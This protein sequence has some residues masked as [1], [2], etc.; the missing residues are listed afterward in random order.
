MGE[1][2]T[3][4]SV[5]H[6]LE[7]RLEEIMTNQIKPIPQATRQFSIQLTY[8]M[9]D[10]LDEIAKQKKTKRSKLIF[11]I[12]SEYLKKVKIESPITVITLIAYIGYFAAYYLSL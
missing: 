2:V 3:I 5:L 9:I 10:E 4:L 12:I 6:S 8:N 11:S 1:I 7:A